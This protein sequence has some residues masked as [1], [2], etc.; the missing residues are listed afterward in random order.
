MTFGYFAVSFMYVFCVFHVFVLQYDMVSMY[1][2]SLFY[3]F[4]CTMT[5]MGFSISVT[6]W[7]KVPM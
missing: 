2:P 7:G 3:Y 6:L 5:M 1:L 4:M